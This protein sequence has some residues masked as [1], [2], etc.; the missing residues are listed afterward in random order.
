LQDN[1]KFKQ[2]LKIRNPKNRLKRIYDACKT[3]KVCGEG[4]DLDV[5]QQQ[6]TDEHVKRRG[7]CGA[8]QPIITVDGMKMLVEFKAPKKKNDDRDFESNS[9]SQWNRSS[10]SLLRGYLYDLCLFNK[11]TS[12]SKEVTVT[13]RLAYMA[14]LTRSL[15]FLGLHPKL[16]RPD[17]MIL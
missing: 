12:C 6:D 4:D 5:Q 17:W 11:L 16:A 10:F 8:Q 15:T 3:K 14:C 7:G 9:L 1:T 13:M 2:A